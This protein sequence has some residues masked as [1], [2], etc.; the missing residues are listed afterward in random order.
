MLEASSVGNS[1]I[2]Q[3]AALLLF[4]WDVRHMGVSLGVCW[5]FRGSPILVLM[6]RRRCAALSLGLCLNHSS[7]CCLQLA[8]LSY[9]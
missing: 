6:H 9:Q 2:G 3:Q 5:V 7:D 8:R 1:F 4:L